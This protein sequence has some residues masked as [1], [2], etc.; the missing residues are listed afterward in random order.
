MKTGVTVTA[1]A[2]ACALL[3]SSTAAV[4][5]APAPEDTTPAVATTA[6]PA[7]PGAPATSASPVGAFGLPFEHLFHE[8]PDRLKS[9]GDSFRKDADALRERIQGGFAKVIQAPAGLVKVSASVVS[10]GMRPFLLLEMQ[11][12]RERERERGG[13]GGGRGTARVVVVG[14]PGRGWGRLSGAACRH[15]RAR[16][17]RPAHLPGGAV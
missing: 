2:L 6:P 3:L 1:A 9:L 5:A 13:G 8:A 4:R 10:S 17:R 15:G 16:P 14:S 11:R 7:A 12:E